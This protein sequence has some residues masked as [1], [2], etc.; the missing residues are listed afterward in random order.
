MNMADLAGPRLVV[1]YHSERNSF[2]YLTVPPIRALELDNQEIFGDGNSISNLDRKKVM[3]PF[4]GW[5]PQ[6]TAVEM[7]SE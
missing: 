5:E 7:I 3:N 4:R 2:P 1:K 6:I